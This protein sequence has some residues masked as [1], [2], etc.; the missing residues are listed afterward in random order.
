[1]SF[2]NPVIYAFSAAVQFEQI[3]GNYGQWNPRDRQDVEHQ[4]GLL[5]SETQKCGLLT[6]IATRGRHIETCLV[7]LP[8]NEVEAD[9][10]RP[11]LSVVLGVAV[12]RSHAVESGMH[13]QVIG[14]LGAALVAMFP[15]Q[16]ETGLTDAANL[17]T[18]CIQS[19]DSIAIR[20][21]LEERVAIRAR[22]FTFLV[23]GYKRTGAGQWSTDAPEE[24]AIILAAMLAEQL[25]QSRHD[26]L[27][28]LFPL[29]S[30]TNPIS[31][32]GPITA[33]RYSDDKGLYVCQSA[34]LTDN[35]Q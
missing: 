17:L 35:N 4:A 1:M 32:R 30:F 19:N 26:Q 12:S 24:S 7:A 14:A 10:G 22:C 18:R 20:D 5:A 16:T 8:V 13:M 28:Y 27:R 9:S 25:H 2:V 34:R 11:G 33:H 3:A 23:E 29:D 15:D 6:G 21:K 31:P